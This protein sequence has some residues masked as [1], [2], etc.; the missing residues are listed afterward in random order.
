MAM[1]LLQV[2]NENRGTMA[3]DYTKLSIAEIIHLNSFR[4]KLAVS[5]RKKR[6]I[7]TA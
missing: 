4:E 5:N 6:K 1:L 3:I 2:L 7:V